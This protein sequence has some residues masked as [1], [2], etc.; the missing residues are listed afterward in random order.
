MPSALQ[1]YLTS[2]KPFPQHIHY[3]VGQREFCKPLPGSVYQVGLAVGAFTSLQVLEDQRLQDREPFPLT[4]VNESIEE[5][6]TYR[7]RG[8]QLKG[9]R[10]GLVFIF[11]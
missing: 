5:S 1:I 10:P 9:R 3:S 4:F 7:L 8:K 11:N 6:V 2:Q